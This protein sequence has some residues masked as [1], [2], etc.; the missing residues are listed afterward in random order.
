MILQIDLIKCRCGN[1]LEIKNSRLCRKCKS[2]YDKQY[3]KNRLEVISE[4]KKKYRESNKE[5]I[6][7]KQR[8]NYLINRY[9]ILSERNK[10][11]HPLSRTYSNMLT[12]CYNLN[13]EAYSRYGGRGIIVCDRWLGREGFNNFLSDLGPRPEGYTLERKD[14][15]LGYNPDNCEWA[16]RKEQANNRRYNLDY[17]KNIS[18]DSCILHDGL[19]VTLKE[20]SDI[21]GIYLPIIK[22]RYALFGDINKILGKGIVTCVWLFDGNYYTIRELSVI[23]GINRNTLYYRLVKSNWSVNESMEIE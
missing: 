21:T 8:N 4:R 2:D 14:N 7:K 17:R 18:E 15:N 11:I 22:D 19:S 20:L 16:S 6:N 12:R 23:S 10:N 5:E 13:N 1:S 9:K 3:R